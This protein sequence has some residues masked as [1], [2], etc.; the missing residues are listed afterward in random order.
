METQGLEA[1][2]IP[3]GPPSADFF[4][5]IHNIDGESAQAAGGLDAPPIRGT[6]RDDEDDGGNAGELKEVHRTAKF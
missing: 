2:S 3:A 6:A 1:G 5:L 4:H